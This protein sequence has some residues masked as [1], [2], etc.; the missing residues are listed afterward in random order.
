MCAT[1]TSIGIYEVAAIERPTKLAAEGGA[2]AKLVLAPT[3]VIANG[4][5]GAI[6]EASKKITVEFDAQRT[7][8]LVRR[9]QGNTI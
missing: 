3:S 2:L 7:D 4:R 5:S 9:F 8:W 6:I 1:D